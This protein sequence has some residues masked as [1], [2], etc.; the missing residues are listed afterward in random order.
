MKIIVFLAVLGLVLVYFRNSISVFL[1]KEFRTIEEIRDEE[2]ALQPMI[3]KIA[4]EKTETLLKRME[5]DLSELE[6][7]TIQ[8]VLRKRES[9]I[10]SL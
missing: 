9:Q 5:E 3:E 6:R 8:I 1:N 4:G 10:S 2:V 7:R